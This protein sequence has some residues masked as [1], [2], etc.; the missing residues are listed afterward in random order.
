MSDIP[1][2]PERGPRG[3]FNSNAMLTIIGVGVVAFIAMLILGAYAPDLRSG[4][5]GGAHALSNGAIGY[6]GLVRLAQETG[7]NPVII[8]SE[9]DLDS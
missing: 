5:N 7:R 6:S 3:P 2:H 4:K 1:V 9:Q 8:R